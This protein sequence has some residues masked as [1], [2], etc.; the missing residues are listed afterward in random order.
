LY[1]VSST[2]SPEVF[3]LSVWHRVDLKA[4]IQPNEKGPSERSGQVTLKKQLYMMLWSFEWFERRVRSYPLTATLA[5][6]LAES[7]P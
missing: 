6:T 3:F 1:V 2:F 4:N 7:L 5:V